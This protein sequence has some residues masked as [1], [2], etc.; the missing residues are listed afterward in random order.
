MVGRS[1]VDQIQKTAKS[2]KIIRIDRN[3][4]SISSQLKNPLCV[5][6]AEEINIDRDENVDFSPL[7]PK[8]WSDDSLDFIRSVLRASEFKHDGFVVLFCVENNP[9]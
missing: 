5:S 6:G 9:G 3:P 7:N 2:G 4:I 1:Y 8:T